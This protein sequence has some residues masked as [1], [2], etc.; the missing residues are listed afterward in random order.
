MSTNEYIALGVLVLVFF[1]IIERRRLNNIPI[2]TSM[3][4]GAGLMVGLQAISIEDAVKAINLDVIIFLFGM[5]SIVSALD[6]S[7][8]LRF[9]A[10]KMLSKA[11]D[12]AN[13][14]LLVFVIGLGILSA[15]LVNDTIALLGI[16]L[17]IHISRQIGVRPTVLFIALAF[18]ISIGSV[19]TPIGNPQNLLIAIKSGISLPFLTFIKWLIIPTILNLFLT[20]FILK[21]YFKKE[22]LKV[23]IHV[24]DDS[25][26]I[27]IK[28]DDLVSTNVITNQYLARTSVIILVLTIAGFIVSEILQYIFHVTFFNIS[29]I[30]ALGAI[31]L[32]A[33]SNERRE[34]LY[35]IDYS[36]LVF[37]AAMFVFTAALWT[38]GLIPDIMSKISNPSSGH[39]NTINNNAV[40]SIVSVAFSQ[41]LSNVPFV[42]L[43]NNVMID[44]GFNAD[45]V[46]EWMMLAAASTIAGNLTIFGAA[47]N[48]IIIEAAESR[49]V[50]AFSYSEFLKIGSIVTVTNL[51][52]YYLF[53]TFIFGRI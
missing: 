11:N 13:S 22:F 31:A 32:Y 36:V 21:V 20:Y 42:A 28:E 30:A 41:I 9:V 27:T 48:V 1:L 33:L 4:I 19:M 40:I 49:S 53:I 6:R 44:N 47:S 26:I 10:A 15:F 23:S 39:N 7:G 14:I 37:F 29:V 2:W 50:K 8:V 17:V 24:N 46:S 12:N 51:L 45:D 3:L 52:V 35:N 34:L 16:P 43:Y 18:G 25:K 5:F 38:S